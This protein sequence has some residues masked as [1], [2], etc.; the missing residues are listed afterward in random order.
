[1][2]SVL[3]AGVSNDPL[4]WILTAAT[5]LSTVLFFVKGRAKHSV[6]R[7]PDRPSYRAVHRPHIPPQPR[8]AKTNHA[9]AVKKEVVVTKI[10]VHP[11]KSCRGTSVNRARYTE[12]G[13]EN[14]R[15]WCIIDAN[16]RSII[17]A[18]EIPKL[19]LIEPRLA[20]D[21]FSE[22]GGLLIVT[23]PKGNDFATFSLPIEPTPDILDQWNLIEE[24]VMFG[25]YKIDGYICQPL[26][27]TDSSPSDVLSE[28]LGKSVHLMMKGPAPRSCPPTLDFPN[29]QA[30]SVY[31]DGYPLLVVS[32]ESLV[33][34]Q[35]AVK[36]A[37]DLGLD[38]IKKVGGMDN[39]RWS[40]ESLVM[41]RFRP[42]IVLKGS[43]APFIEDTWRKIAIGPKHDT[44]IRQ[45]ESMDITLVS[46]C[47][48]CLL[49]NVDPKSGVRDAAVPYK[50]LMQ[51][52]TGVDRAN[53]S[54]PCFGCNGVPEGDGTIQVG[55][56]ATIM[57]L[58]EGEIVVEAQ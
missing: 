26:S 20:Y 1:M 7:T 19:V 24:C 2:I 52:R 14:D 5:L 32:E 55:D 29:L 25:T 18:R 31:Q 49:P 23:V 6:I 58:L 42:N 36:T 43:D 10:L 50:V 38:A 56:T 12:T 51:F 21:P 46:K 48:R 28:Y 54:K 8:P 13:L 9:V 34:V 41:E 57:Q 45:K 39:E 17:T 11:I 53:M 44:R 16:T 15:K 47:A 30:E 22:H 27:P 37:A 3:A 4:L 40:T 33:A 35:E